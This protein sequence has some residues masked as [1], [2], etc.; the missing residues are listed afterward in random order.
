[1]LRNYLIVALRNLARQRIL[2]FINI[3]GLA[4][5]IAC[6]GLILQYIRFELS[7]DR[8]HP[9]ADRIFQVLRGERKADNSVHYMAAVSGALGPEISILPEVEITTRA[10]LRGASVRAGAR[11]F[12]ANYSLVE[13]SFFDIFRM[14]MADGSDPLV[15]LSQ[16]ASVLITESD[17][18][19]FFAA[20][21]P[22]GKRVRIHDSLADGDYII[23]GVLDDSPSNT[24]LGYGFVTIHAPNIRFARTLWE[25]WLPGTWRNV[26]VFI[27][28]RE[29][30]DPQAVESRLKQMMDRHLLELADVGAYKLQALTRKRLYNTHDLG[31]PSTHSID[32]IYVL[33]SVAVIVVLIACVNFVN[34]STA[35]AGRRAREVGI[36]KVAGSTRGR[37]IAQFMIESVLI[38]LLSGGLACSLAGL[39]LPVF[40]D[41]L[42]LELSLDPG[43]LP[44]A[45]GLVLLTGLLSGAYPAFFLSSFQPAAVLKGGQSSTR[46]QFLRRA[47]VV[48]QFAM[49]TMLMTGAFTVHR[50]LIHI[51][52]RDLGYDSEGIVVVPTVMQF[53]RSEAETAMA[54]YARHPNIL[55]ATSTTWEPLLSAKLVTLRRADRPEGIGAR[56]IGTDTNFV[57]TYGV[58]LEEGRQ[59]AY[60][61]NRDLGSGPNEFLLNRAAV[62]A[63]GFEDSPLGRQLALTGV[64]EVRLYGK[65]ESSARSW[66]WSRIS[67]TSPPI[68]PSSP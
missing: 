3:L 10:L 49:S 46:A 58:R 30:V 17:A 56:A 41:Q 50:Q 20:E 28:L 24:S 67:H 5:G 27:R 25:D 21:D 15:A 66:A 40:N 48:F 47:L 55:S 45:L 13:P 33:A 34:L 65:K 29:G 14:A 9:H 31:S 52:E 23:S 39:A 54:A 7:F 32:Q 35:R 63:L 51:S 68:I 8:H 44:W 62:R 16:P 1:M 38:A 26:Q 12:R 11:L 43:L 64:D 53:L 18:R 22:V 37:L 4:V 60:K 6:A 61:V 36:R 59:I 57:H 19:R 42:E 2:S